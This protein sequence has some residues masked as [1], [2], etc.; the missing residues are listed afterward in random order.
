V[1]LF[2][3]NKTY[4]VAGVPCAIAVVPS[5]DL[6]A[7]VLAAKRGLVPHVGIMS[8][9]AALAAYRHGDGWL[10]D[11]IAYLEENRDTVA[12]FVTE[13]LAGIRLTPIEGTYL[14]WLD[15]REAVSENPHQFFLREGRIALNDGATFGPGGEGFVRLNFACPRSTLLDGLR[16]VRDALTRG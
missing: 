11:L 5:D 8:Y 13:E 3:P 4:N 12:R 10:A 16:R 7:R 1:T 15:C 6:R 9:V 14:A 2:A